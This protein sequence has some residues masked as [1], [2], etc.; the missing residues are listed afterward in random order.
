MSSKDK[1]KA[2]PGKIQT[3]IDR[4]KLWLP[5]KVAVKAS[6]SKCGNCTQP[7]Q[8][9]CVD[10]AKEL[11]KFCTT[12]LHHPD[13]K[14]EKHSLEDIVQKS[15]GVKPEV[16]IISPILLD[17]IVIAASFFLL[18]GSG[19][20]E[21]YFQGAS[22]CPGLGRV[23][24]SVARLDANIFFYWKNEFAQYCD[25]EDSYWRFFMDTWVRGILT[26]TDS[27]ILLISAF[28]RALT[29]E[30]F[31]RVIISPIVAYTYAVLAYCVQMV[32]FWLHS[33]LY[34]KLEGDD[35]TVTKWLK[36]ISKVV[37]RFHFAQTLGIIDG[38]KPA[39]R[40]HRRK[41]PSTD[42]AEYV[43]YMWGR[44]FRML[45]YYQSQA[46]TAC[47]VILKG[48]L[49]AA[50]LIRIF[51]ILF[52]GTPFVALAW[53]VGQGA[54]A[55]QHREWFKT[56]TGILPYD[57]AP[58]G[59]AYYTDWFFAVAARQA[60]VNGIPVLRLLLGEVGVAAGEGVF[61][62]VP[63]LL[64]LWPLFL[65]L[66]LQ[67]GYKLIIQRQQKRFSDLW[68]KQFREECWGK[69]S[70]ENPCGGTAYKE[71]HFSC[72]KKKLLKPQAMPGS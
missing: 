30:E 1:A 70:R 57:E 4:A 22:Y 56:H 62:F 44:N 17:L 24:W 36:R 63:V 68:K 31:L 42:F 52:G 21:D 50:V 69:M 51:C 3:F 60:V 66:G 49:A 47:N 46:R 11:C 14:M 16:R 54:R 13:T 39:P 7:A 71:L 53:A 38:K 6:K 65:I 28:I 59:Q 35:H 12:L 37:D 15:D 45:D 58:A 72:E 43:T 5:W 41:R 27:W 34:E 9:Y 48:S 25:W 67:Q 10:C 23:R 26:N 33:F 32:E 20:K 8:V 64:R 61:K 55:E 40:T 18:S 2:K 29:F 19:I